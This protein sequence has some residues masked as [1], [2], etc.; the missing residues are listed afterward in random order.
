MV[1][2]AALVSSWTTHTLEQ[3]IIQEN[4]LNTG[5][6]IMPHH[7]VR[8]GKKKFPEVVHIYTGE[9]TVLACDALVLVTARIPNASLE[10][11]LIHI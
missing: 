8:P 3:E 10:L 7:F 2:P 11:S 9:S 1:T 4:L 5:I 6:K